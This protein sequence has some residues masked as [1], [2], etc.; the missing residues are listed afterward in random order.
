MIII[1]LDGTQETAAAGSP[2][3]QG[4]VIESGGDASVLVVFADG[5]TLAMGRDSRSVLDELIYDPEGGKVEGAVSLLEGTF[6]FVSGEIAESSP[7]ALVINTSVAIYGVRGTKVAFH[8][9]ED[10][11]TTVALLEDSPGVTG[12]VLV[13]NAGG[14]ELLNLA[15]QHRNGGCEHGAERTADHDPGGNRF[16]VRRAVRGALSARLHAGRTR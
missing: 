15:N 16:G 10:G 14:R 2:V 8:V 4:D 11:K 7:D 1:R 3:F 5:T 13:S 12:E 9:A 6:S